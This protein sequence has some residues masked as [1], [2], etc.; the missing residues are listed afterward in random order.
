MSTI[1][2][3][4]DS[5]LIGIVP[6]E[7]ISD[8]TR[9]LAKAVASLV[10]EADH[11]VFCHGGR[12]ETRY[13]H[14]VMAE[15]AKEGIDPGAPIDTCVAM[16]EGYLAFHLLEVLEQALHAIGRE[17]A[18]PA[19]ALLT[20]TAP[21]QDGALP[22][23]LEQEAVRTLLKDHAILIAGGAG[24]IP[25]QFTHGRWEGTDHI[26]ELAPTAAALADLSAADR[27]VFLVDSRTAL[28]EGPL[29]PKAAETMSEDAST[30]QSLREML[31]AASLFVQGN[32]AREAV[33]AA[34]D[35]VPQDLTRPGGLHIT[36]S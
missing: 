23:I 19:G 35:S 17:D 36:V 14:D 8:K 4:A 29:S 31:R 10:N 6:A 18:L 22:E 16:S 34:V 33:I 20:Q 15:G 7:E 5:D 27:L 12:A 1:V 21:G 25:V 2:V 9:T 24:G 3:A 30:P 26:L 32:G 13:I 28:P 11:V